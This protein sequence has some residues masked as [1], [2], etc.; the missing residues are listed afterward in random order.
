M[1]D[2]TGGRPNDDVSVRPARARPKALMRR[3]IVLAVNMHNYVNVVDGI[4]IAKVSCFFGS[5][6]PDGAVALVVPR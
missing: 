5:R 1:E 2:Y 3:A 4:N 6:L